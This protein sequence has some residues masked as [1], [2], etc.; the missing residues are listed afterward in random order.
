MVPLSLIAVIATA[1]GAETDIYISHLLDPVR[2][3]WYQDF[4]GATGQIQVFCGNAFSI[5]LQMQLGNRA[6][7]KCVPTKTVGREFETTGR[8]GSAWTS[9]RL[10]QAHMVNVAKATKARASQN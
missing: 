10:Y 9:H 3:F 7:S 1:D 8:I 5:V 6:G 2:L 4:R